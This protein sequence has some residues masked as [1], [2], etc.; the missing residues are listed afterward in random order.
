MQN[1][2]FITCNPIV[3][4]GISVTFIGVLVLPYE[5]FSDAVL[6]DPQ[7]EKICNKYNNRPFHH[8]P[9]QNL[10]LVHFP[11]YHSSFHYNNYYLI[12]QNLQDHR[13]GRHYVSRHE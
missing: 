11:R 12:V 13:Q 4:K 6:D 5:H 7:S 10:I 8:L 3:S 9:H 1:N 2:Y